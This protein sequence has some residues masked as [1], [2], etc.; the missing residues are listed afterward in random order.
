M[1]GVVGWDRVDKHDAS[2]DV[3]SALLWVDKYSRVM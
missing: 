3:T 1:E 2:A